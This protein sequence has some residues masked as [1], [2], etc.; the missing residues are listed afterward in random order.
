L[1][2]HPRSSKS[3]HGNSCAADWQRIR[4]GLKGDMGQSAPGCNASG[5]HEG[6]ISDQDRFETATKTPAGRRKRHCRKRH[7][8]DNHQ[9]KNIAQATGARSIRWIGITATGA[10]IPPPYAINVFAFRT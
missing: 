3:R 4:A 6:K 1:A 7:L 5:F 8:R 2:G 10:V 9:R